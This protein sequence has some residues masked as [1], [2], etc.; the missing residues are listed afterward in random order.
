MTD[1]ELLEKA[2][3]A[4]GVF[5]TPETLKEA[6]PNLEWDEDLETYHTP[7]GMSGAVFWRGYSGEISG[8]EREE[9]NP[10]TDDGDALRLAHGLNVPVSI[11]ISNGLTTVSGWTF[12]ID[13]PHGNDPLAATRRAIVRAAAA[14]GEAM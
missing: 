1:R 4:A 5:L 7:G 6:L 9:W 10:L 14:I 3:K 12:D 2:A 8:T 13:E 11:D